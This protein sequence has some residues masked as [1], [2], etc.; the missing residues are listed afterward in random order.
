MNNFKK[1]SC[2]TAAFLITMSVSSVASA[3]TTKQATKATAINAASSKS[4]AETKKIEQQQAKKN[5]TAR[6]QPITVTATHLPPVTVTA[7]EH[8][9]AQISPTGSHNVI[10][11]EEI[12]VLTP[13]STIDVLQFTPGVHAVEEFGRGLRPNIGVRG[14]DP[15]RSRNVLILA[16]GVPIQP[17]VYGDPASYFNV[18]VE[19]IEHIEI[20]KGNSSALYGPKTVGGVINYILHRPPQKQEFR[21]SETFREGGL[22]TTNASYGNRFGEVGVLFNFND[23]RGSL[24]RQNTH[25]DVQDFSIR[26]TSPLID[27][28]EVDLRLSFHNEEAQTPGGLSV[29]QFNSNANASQRSNDVFY[30]RRFA[31][32]LKLDTPLTKTLSL[33]TLTYMNSFKRDWFIANGLDGEAPTTNNQYL[34]DFVVAGVEPK[35]RWAPNDHMDLVAGTKVHFEE[36]QDILRVGNSAYT[37]RG[38]TIQDAKL[39]S[40]VV[41]PFASMNLQL[42][43]KVIIT[44]GVRYEHITQQR[45]IGLSDGIGGG[46]DTRVTTEVLG[47]VGIAYTPID[48][49][50]FFGNY[51][52]NFQPPT[53]NE[54]IDPTTGTSNDIKAETSNNF[55]VGMR[56]RFADWVS[57]EATGFWTNFDN[58]IITEAGALTNAGKTRQRGVE[59]GV[60][61]GYSL[62]LSGNLTAT[63]VDT[64]FLN[65]VNKGNELPEAP[66]VRLGWA[67]AY[68][69]TLNTGVARIRVDGNFV[70][71]RFTD[72]ANT[73]EES[74]DGGSGRLPAYHVWNL[75]LDY[76]MGKQRFGS[77]RFSTGVNNLF[78]KAYR[79]RRQASFGGIIPGATRTFYASASTTF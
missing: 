38:T 58:Q 71:K 68:A 37:R 49:I 52:R 29:A 42:T 55:E 6:L 61:L 73:V 67:T 23:K 78:D 57:V 4:T 64:E 63:Y 62:G 72:G 14:L 15:A 79:L 35:L 21:L 7:P 2:A 40:F 13:L 47:G 17:A 45:K 26:V 11:K 76:D 12:E 25:T 39:Q 9:S 27:G 70:D 50:E 36:Q 54:A 1:P 75:R 60:N 31:A 30:G 5:V 24:R 28:G 44:P 48:A 16:D 41:A 74:A 66:N 22:F 56:S 32:T 77:W 53:F 8:I 69:H 18:P 19:Q 34:R 46:G 51:S 33:D 65:G 59:G 10:S 20:I 3:E 43:D